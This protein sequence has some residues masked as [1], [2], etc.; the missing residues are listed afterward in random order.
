[1]KHEEYVKM[2]NDL[3]KMNDKVSAKLERVANFARESDMRGPKVVEAHLQEL[4][5]NLCEAINILDWFID[6]E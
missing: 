5:N 1:M 6:E 2:Q 3:N 4:S